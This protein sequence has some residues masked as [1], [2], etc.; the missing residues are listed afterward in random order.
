MIAP[1]PRARVIPLPR[2]VLLLVLLHLDRV[3][4]RERAP[5]PRAPERRTMPAVSV[6]SEHFLD[7]L[8]LD[9][10]VV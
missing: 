3:I 10:A 2:V 1:T 7:L 5:L 6:C 4:A 9:S 8:S